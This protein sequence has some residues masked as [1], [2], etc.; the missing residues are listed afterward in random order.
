MKRFSE[1]IREARL[2]KRLT[3]IALAKATGTQKGYLSGIENEK[4][5]APVP[6]LVQRLCKILD[7]DY[8][9]MLARSVFEKLPRGLL[10]HDLETVLDEARIDGLSKSSGS[11]TGL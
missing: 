7:L 4:V 3:L 6:K 9:G 10:Y 2:S 8:S 1:I 11:V 5:N